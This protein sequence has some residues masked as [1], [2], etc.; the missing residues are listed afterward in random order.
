VGAPWEEKNSTRESRFT[1]ELSMP[2][3]QLRWMIGSSVG[4]ESGGGSG[5]AG[6]ACWPRP[7]PTGWKG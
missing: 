2:I 4:N 5:L 7:Q 3:A 6:V 1:W